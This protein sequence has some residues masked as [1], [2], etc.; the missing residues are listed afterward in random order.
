MVEQDLFKD[1]FR[2]WIMSYIIKEYKSSYELSRVR[3]SMKRTLNTAQLPRILIAIVFFFNVQCA[4]VFIINPT[5]YAP[6]F[7]LQGVAGAA[8]V[9]GMGILFL[10]WNVPYFVALLDPLKHRTALIEAVIMQAIGLLGETLLLITLPQ[11]H[12]P[13]RS[14]ALRFIVFDGSGLIFLTI[15]YIYTQLLRRLRI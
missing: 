5:S 12:L 6:A 15:A 8:M 1:R 2:I 7:E 3:F 14:T 11:G 9:R 4:L 10:M 13:L